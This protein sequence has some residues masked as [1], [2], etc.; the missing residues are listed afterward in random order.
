MG[1]HVNSRAG[2]SSS[3]PVLCAMPVA[4]PP[5]VETLERRR[6]L[7]AGPV[8][9]A[10]GRSWGDEAEH[11]VPATRGEQLETSIDIQTR[12]FDF[13]AR[14]HGLSI[15]V[16]SGGH[17]LDEKP[18]VQYSTAS[19]TLIP[20]PPSLPGTYIVHASFPGNST[21]AA[22]SDSAQFEIRKGTARIV[23][24]ADGGVENGKAYAAKG[25]VLGLD[26]RFV[27]TPEFT[28]YSA[29]EFDPITKAGNPLDGPPST[30]G[31]YWVVATYPGNA[32][33]NSASDSKSFTITPKKTLSTTNLSAPG[34]AFNGKPIKAEVTVMSNGQTLP[35]PDVVIHYYDSDHHEL[36]GPPTQPG[37]YST[38]ATFL[39]DATHEAGISNTVNFTI[40]KATPKVSM[41]VNTEV[42]S[43]HPVKAH[44]LVTG[45]ENKTLGTPTI[46]YFTFSGTGPTSTIPKRLSGPPSTPGTYFAVA[47]WPGNADYNAGS[48]T[49]SFI[50]KAP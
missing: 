28:Y 36:K 13:D 11:R 48:T 18:K 41:R 15:V 40:S 5:L 47:T 43:G 26:N 39:G 19:G 17:T 2:S 46:T 23:I 45:V 32:D 3:H 7:S 31:D 16:K 25:K 33:Y 9:V 38:S 30:E 35:H 21:Y 37:N 20:E 29:N 8:V 42:P 49:E 24:T 4:T 14:Q 34:G 44:G 6:L 27:A 1:H 22:S 10:D 50:I 12:D